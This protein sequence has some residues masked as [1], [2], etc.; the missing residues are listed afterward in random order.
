MEPKTSIPLSCCIITK[1]E[2]LRIA[3]CIRAVKGLVDEVIVVDSGSTDATVSI[4]EDE[5]ARVI[6]HEWPGYGPQKRYSEE[7]ARNDWVLNLDADEMMTPELYVEIQSLMRDG[8]QLN[9]YRFKIRNVYP[10]KS[11]PRLWADYHNYVRLYNRR[12]VRFRESLVHDTVDTKDQLVGQLKGSVTHF[13]A[14]SYEHIRSKLDSYTN[15]QAKVLKKPAWSIWLRLPF[16]YPFVFLRYFLFRC[17]FTGGWD[18]LYSSHLAAE[19]RVNR[20]LK[21]LA[22]QK[23]AKVNKGQS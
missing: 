5:G 8:P 23:T 18:G 15:L 13:S 1:N 4:A 22:A 3:D 7:C 17:H 20:L 19:A 16:E 2:A 6:F 12:V 14:Q 11:K 21:I 10:G 9:A